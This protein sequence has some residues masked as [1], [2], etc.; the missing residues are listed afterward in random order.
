MGHH[1]HKH[2]LKA[3]ADQHLTLLNDNIELLKKQAALQ[4]EKI[5]YLQAEYSVLQA[6]NAH[7]EE[8]IARFAKLGLRL[9]EENEVEPN[10]TRDL[11]DQQGQVVGRMTQ[12]NGNTFLSGI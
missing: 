8:Q 4:Q 11:V 7:L 2:A 3:I 6:E 9:P 5:A 12:R 1:K 10:T